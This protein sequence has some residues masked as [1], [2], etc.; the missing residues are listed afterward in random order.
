M[1]VPTGPAGRP[2]RLTEGS[3]VVL[4]PATRGSITAGLWAERRR[5]NRETSVVEGW[6]HLHEA[7]NFLNLELAAG[8]HEGTPYVGTLPFLDSDLYKW[9]EAVAWT[10]AD[11][12]IEPAEVGLTAAW[13]TV[14]EATP[15]PPRAAGRVVTDEDGAGAEALVEFLVAGKYV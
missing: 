11:L 6:D 3:R 9:L 10:L 13:T 12:G 2:V 4:R 8:Q 1:Q 14:L 5:V 7:G 15:R